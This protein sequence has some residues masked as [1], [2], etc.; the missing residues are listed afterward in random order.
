MIVLSKY[1]WKKKLFSPTVL[2]N[3]SGWQKKKVLDRFKVK[4]NGIQWNYII[5][6]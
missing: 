4:N 6:I 2:Q 3:W 1:N 5:L